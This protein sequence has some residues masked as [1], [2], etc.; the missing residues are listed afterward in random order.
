M[1][2]NQNC[3]PLEDTGICGRLACEVMPDVG[4]A[5]ECM[6]KCEVRYVNH[7]HS[8]LSLVV[9][10]KVTY[11]PSLKTQLHTQYTHTVKQIARND[12]NFFL[13]IGLKDVC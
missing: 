13:C 10:S 8:N 1:K 5:R 4:T 2:A 3:L 12:A 11:I 6:Y 7:S 9:I